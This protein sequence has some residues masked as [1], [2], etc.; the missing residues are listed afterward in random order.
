MALAKAT[1]KTIWLCKLL[2][3]LIFPQKDATIIYSN[4][5]S[6]IALIENPRY[7]SHNKHI[8]TQ[9]HFTRERGSLS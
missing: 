9:Y 6:A 1:T 4:P 7:H 3:K 2:A 5:Q 8:D